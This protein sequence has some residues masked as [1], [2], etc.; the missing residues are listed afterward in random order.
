M[1]KAAGRNY[2][3]MNSILYNG[4]NKTQNCLLAVILINKSLVLSP[5]VWFT[6]GLSWTDL[7][8]LIANAVYI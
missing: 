7:V 8:V 3:K 4:L 6:L 2:S 5:N 1:A